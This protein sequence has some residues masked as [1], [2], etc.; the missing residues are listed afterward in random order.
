MS[1][2]K[3]IKGQ[4]IVESIA[5][6]AVL[7]IGF[8]SLVVLMSN[9]IGLSRVNSEHYI[10]TYL[11]AEGIEVVKNIID[12]N[13]I[14]GRPWNNGLAI[15]GTYEVEY[16][17]SSLLSNQNRFLRFDSNSKTYNYSNTQN[18]PFIRKIEI[19][20]INSNHIRVKS[21]VSWISRGGAQ[22]QVDLED[23]FYNSF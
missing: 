1:F 10:A 15:N 7:T 12:T 23:H 2:L 22:F 8:L 18:T 17:S 6:L 20:N 14:S 3:N 19:T 5:A 9:A 16:N 21:T 4:A 13:V 11:A